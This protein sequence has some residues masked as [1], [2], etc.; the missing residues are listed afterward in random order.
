MYGEET[1]STESFV[2]STL[3]DMSYYAGI[4][5]SYNYARSQIK[6]SIVSDIVDAIYDETPDRALQLIKQYEKKNRTFYD[7]NLDDITKNGKTALRLATE[8]NYD[9]IV[10]VL[11][12]QGA[13]MD[14]P[15][16]DG[17]SPLAWA[18]IHHQKS[19]LDVMTQFPAFKFSQPA[20]FFKQQLRTWLD[21]GCKNNV[22]DV[23]S[24]NDVPQE[25]AYKRYYW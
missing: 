13:D 18:K 12:S 21:N 9:G 8:R 17:L 7:D 24:I 11:L 23:F 15:Q 22:R 20:G 4:L 6:N 1:R 3:D 16:A 2:L 10:C 25:R 14:L 19:I 5:V